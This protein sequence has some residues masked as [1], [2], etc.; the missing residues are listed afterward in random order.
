MDLNDKKYLIFD[1]DYTIDKLII[2][3]TDWKAGELAVVKRYDPQTELA[4]QEVHFPVVNKFVE[5]FGSKLNLDLIDFQAEYESSHYTGHE[6]IQTV[7]DFILNNQ[8]YD[9]L[10]WSNNHSRTIQPIMKELGLADKFIRQV[11][12]DKNDFAKPHRSGFLKL[13]E[14]NTPLS[15]YLLIGDAET[16]QWAAD[17]AG[18]DFLHV[19]D[20]VRLIKS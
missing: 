3:W 9:L 12:R 7:V 14:P 13:Y 4:V 20:F 19:E 10:L 6:P 15:E 18:I 1:F 16:D 17:E 5:R 8:T 11:T 2:D